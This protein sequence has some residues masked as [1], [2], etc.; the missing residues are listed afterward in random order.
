ML[1]SLSS[2]AVSA[3]EKLSCVFEV[4]S[5]KTSYELR[6]LRSST[7]KLEL[8]LTEGD[9]QNKTFDLVQLIVEPNE[10][11]MSDHEVIIFEEDLSVGSVIKDH[12]LK[13]DA[14]RLPDQLKVETQKIGDEVLVKLN[15][16][17]WD[18]RFDFGR[19]FY[20]QL[21][22]HLYS[23]ALFSKEKYNVEIP[24]VGPLFGKYDGA[25]RRSVPILAKCARARA[26]RVVDTERGQRE[27][28][29]FEKKLKETGAGH[30]QVT[31]Q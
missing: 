27:E 24:I 20:S 14:F 16:N 28:F 26:Q 12:G 11:G 4:Q 3:Q 18:Y 29:L 10:K 25:V 22:G 9:V 21:S 8:D 17:H 7:V 31:A 5:N 19:G 13:Y 6:E 15:T 30:S 1:L 2:A 23:E